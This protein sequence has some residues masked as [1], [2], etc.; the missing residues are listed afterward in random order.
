[1]ITSRLSA[2]TSQKV[3]CIYQQPSPD[4]PSHL[5]LSNAATS[6]PSPRTG[7]IR[8]QNGPRQRFVF[9]DR[10][11]DRQ[12]LHTFYFHGRPDQRLQRSPQNEEWD[13]KCYVVSK[14]TET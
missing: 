12:A 10:D 14:L 6:R 3:A 1:M 4:H 7:V 2:L 11:T 13:Q 9:V 5:P 8:G